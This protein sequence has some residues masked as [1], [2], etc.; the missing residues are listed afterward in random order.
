MVFLL[1]LISIFSCIYLRFFFMI[2]SYCPYL[3]LNGSYPRRKSFGDLLFKKYTLLQNKRWRWCPPPSPTDN[4]WRTKLT[5]IK[6]Y[7]IGK[8]VYQR[9][10][11]I[12]DIENIYFDVATF[13]AI[14]AK[15][16]RNSS[17]IAVRKIFR[18]LMYEHISYHCKDSVNIIVS[19]N[20]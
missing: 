14:F 12:L 9:L 2:V 11:F 16:L 19:R 15:W 17:R 7:I 6:L 20:I 8:G 1:S 13:W 18:I 5:P 4:F 10:R 3:L